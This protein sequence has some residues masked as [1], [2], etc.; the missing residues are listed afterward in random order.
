MISRDAYFMGRDK[1]FPPTP[2]MESDANTLLLR[3]ED[4]CYDLGIE[5]HDEDVGSGYRPGRYNIEAGGSPKSAHLLCLAIDLDDD[6]MRLQKAI[7]A[8]PHLLE[9]H[10]LYMEDPAYT[11]EVNIVTGKKER[12]VHLQTRATRKRIFLPY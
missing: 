6:D 10:G 3:V 7:L 2:Q 4:L 11:V 9:K 1:E 12:W 5:L 8:A